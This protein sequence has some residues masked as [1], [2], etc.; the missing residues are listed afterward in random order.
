M[1]GRLLVWVLRWIYALA[2]N[3]LS[4]ILT[5]KAG[6]LR[7][8]AFRWHYKGWCCCDRSDSQKPT[9]FSPK[10]CHFSTSTQWFGLGIDGT[11]MENQP[12]GSSLHE[13]DLSPSHLT[14]WTGQFGL[15]RFTCYVWWPWVQVSRMLNNVTNWSML[16]SALVSISGGRCKTISSFWYRYLPRRTMHMKINYDPD[17]PSGWLDIIIIRWTLRCGRPNILR[18]Q[19]LEL[20]RFTHKVALWSLQQY[21]IMRKRMC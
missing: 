18:P 2:Y 5:R 8:E 7:K 19:S 13:R 16:F 10:G 12:S 9:S 6:L 1:F 14:V 4:S 21:I 3:C 17:G 11:I 15:I 20:R